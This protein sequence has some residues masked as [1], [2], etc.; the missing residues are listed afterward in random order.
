MVLLH[1]LGKLAP[2][3]MDRI[4]SSLQAH[5][6]PAFISYGAYVGEIIGP[7]LVVLGLRAR[8]GG[9]LIVA[10]MLFAIGLVHMDHLFGLGRSGGWALELQGLYLFGGLAIALLG[11]GRYS[12]GGH[13][14]R[15][16]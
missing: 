7:L 5:G 8:L 2:G 16:N 15:W 1:G 10:N 11:A 12:A 14:G 9:L 6:L 4:G 3:S 13:N